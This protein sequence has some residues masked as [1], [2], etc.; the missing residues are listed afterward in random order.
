M[1]GSDLSRPGT[2]ITERRISRKAFTGHY[3]AAGLFGLVLTVILFMT[4]Q[5]LFVPVAILPLLGVF[6]YAFVGDFL[7][8]SADAATTRKIVD[9]Y[10]KQ[11]TLAGDG[12]FKNY[13]RWQPRQLYGQIYV[14]PALMESFKA[15][16]AQTNSTMSDQT[17]ALMSRVNTLAQPVTYSLTN[18]GL[19]PLH[20]LHLP[21]NLVLMAVTG[22]SD[23]PRSC[24]ARSRRSPA[25][26]SP[27]ALMTTGC[28]SPSSA[29]L[30]AGPS[31]SPR[32][33]R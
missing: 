30:H 11:E 12:N 8:L 10:L 29:M 27:F 22:I 5:G 25:I 33:R 4:G 1:A 21:K 19:G 16:G 18:E 13:T 24:M 23:R 3:I 17:R 32:S 9:S 14:S 7:V 20:E 2:P 15:W 6:A 26:S 31:M 28:R